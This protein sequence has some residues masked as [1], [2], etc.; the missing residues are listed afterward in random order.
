MTSVKRA[1]RRSATE[2]TLPILHHSPPV[3]TQHVTRRTVEALLSME[4]WALTVRA[5][6]EDCG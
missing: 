6:D 5:L 2:S 4:A 1:K 3:V